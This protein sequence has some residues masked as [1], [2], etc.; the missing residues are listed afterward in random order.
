MYKASQVASTRKIAS[1]RLV[2]VYTNS[3]NLKIYEFVVTF[4][5]IYI[6]AMHMQMLKKVFS[7]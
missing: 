7:Y 1:N 4:Q 5:F 6:G 3:H 2:P